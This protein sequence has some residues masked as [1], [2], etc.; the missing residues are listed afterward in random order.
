MVKILLTI[1]LA[2]TSVT[3]LVAFHFG[4]PA[5]AYLAFIPIFLLAMRRSQPVTLHKIDFA[6]LAMMSLVFVWMSIGGLM[7]MSPPEPVPFTQQV[8]TV[9]WYVATFLSYLAVRFLPMTLNDM[10]FTFAAFVLLFVLSVPVVYLQQMDLVGHFYFPE[11]VGLRKAYRFTDVFGITRTR[12]TGFFGNPHEA[13]A[14]QLAL[15]LA[16][17][18][19]AREV[20]AGARLMVFYAVLLMSLGALFL[21]GS[22]SSFILF[23]LTILTYM[24]VFEI[25]WG[26]LVRKVKARPS[27]VLRVA[28]LGTFAAAILLVVIKTDL[29]VLFEK[30]MFMGSGLS[31]IAME[32]R[33]STQVDSLSYLL[34]T[35]P[36]RGLLGWGMGTGGLGAITGIQLLPVNTAD[37]YIVGLL[38]NMGLLGA[39]AFMLLFAYLTLSAVKIHRTISHLEEGAAAPGMR[40]V[41][42]FTVLALIAGFLSTF[43]AGQMNL[44]N[45]TVIAFLC[46]GMVANHY[47]RLLTRSRSVRA[48]GEAAVAGLAHNR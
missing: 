42:L 35:D 11:E 9:I 39:G 18:A 1:A 41:S 32:E 5:V 44:K 3:W 45:Y 15:C 33:I 27:T 16:L 24:V 2:A 22:R 29:R 37:L 30:S 43:V 13:G 17:F 47:D 34:L 31:F 21:T 12:N 19:I 26:R 8:K 23:P 4:I 48:A 6:V 40:I 28:G 7:A 25:G 14:A 10:R 38:S 46:L 20:R 36:V